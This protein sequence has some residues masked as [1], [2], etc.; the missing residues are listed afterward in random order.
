M[1]T[2]ETS[3]GRLDMDA[4]DKLLSDVQNPLDLRK[5]CGYHPYRPLNGC[6]VYAAHY[7]KERHI[8]TTDVTVAK[9][10][11]HQSVDNYKRILGWG[12]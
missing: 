12:R 2:V 7:A 4:S 9:I 3:D 11:E 5:A 6:R 10:V 8:S 1:V